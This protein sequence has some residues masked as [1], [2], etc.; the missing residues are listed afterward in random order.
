[1]TALPKIHPTGWA[2]LNI[3]R[4]GERYQPSN[5]TEGMIFIDAWCSHCARDKAM[6]EGNSVEECDDRELCPIIARSMANG[7]CEEWVY[8]SDGQPRCTEYVEQGQPIPYR[9]PNTPDIFD[10]NASQKGGGQ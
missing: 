7:G 4:A 2:A 8:G 3:D 6:S 1:M 10:E 9:C 5:G